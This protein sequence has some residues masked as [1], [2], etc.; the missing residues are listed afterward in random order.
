MNPMKMFCGLCE[1]GDI[2]F[3]KLLISRKQGDIDAGLLHAVMGGHFKIVELLVEH[4]AKCIDRALEIACS[5]KYKSRHKLVTYLMEH[6]AKFT[7]AA[8]RDAVIYG[9]EEIVE[10]ILNS[11]IIISP[12]LIVEACANG[13][14]SVV[15][16]LMA[17]DY[18]LP[19]HALRAACENKHWDLVARFMQ[20]SD[21]VDDNT[22]MLMI[23]AD[24][25]SVL[26]GLTWF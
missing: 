10:I 21:T 6:G 3:V 15:E 22:L 13:C 24:K 7:P 19:K 20:D 2:G 14:Q 1:R 12:E 11:G 5:Y 16:C 23:D 17:H 4:G 18:T 9:H 8:I 25:L 26:P